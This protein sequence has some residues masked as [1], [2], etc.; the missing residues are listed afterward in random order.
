MLANSNASSEAVYPRS[1][2][3]MRVHSEGR[4]YTV[5]DEVFNCDL[6][7]RAQDAVSPDKL[8]PAL[9][10][11]SRIHD[12]LAFKAYGPHG[13]LAPDLSDVDGD[14]VVAQLAAHCV[15]RT[16][17]LSSDGVSAWAYSS[18]YMAYTVG[19]QLSWHDDRNA[20]WFGVFT[21]YLDPWSSEWGGELDF[22]DCD[23]KELPDCAS[24]EESVVHASI[25]ATTVFPRMNRLAVLKAGTLHR[26]RR[27]DQLAGAN[28]R[29]TI[30]GSVWAIE[31]NGLK[32]VDSDD[33]H[34]ATS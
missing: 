5:Y 21:Y 27:V 28:I 24:H 3:A 2:S 23:S 9:S 13:E 14:D 10:P 8:K 31:Q 18:T 34:N 19:T 1:A 16:H 11:V 26:V 25:N 12:G 29:R 32:A 6:L 7:R 15:R 17:S 22:M 4:R 33:R 20:D 30:S